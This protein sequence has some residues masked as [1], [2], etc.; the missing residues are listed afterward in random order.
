MIILL[1]AIVTI[2]LLD[3]TAFGWSGEVH[4]F[5]DANFQSGGGEYSVPISNVQ[6]CFNLETF[7]D[8]VTS[9][10]WKG[11]TQSGI[12]DGSGARIAFYTGEYCTG[13]VRSWPTE[14]HNFPANFE[15]DGTPGRPLLQLPHGILPAH[16]GVFK[17]PDRDAA[18]AAE[19]LVDSGPAGLG[20]SGR[21]HPRPTPHPRALHRHRN[22]LLFCNSVIFV[23]VW[24]DG[25]HGGD[26]SLPTVPVG[27]PV[28]P[29][30]A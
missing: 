29:R 16:S 25:V 7:N 18:N 22:A 15:L 9:V 12:F 27:I 23:V 10:K 8:K 14:E 21:L 11:I 17:G 20:S 24:L 30:R 28:G 13:T 5:A 19:L 1:V 6:K 4:F 3:H 2:F 26:G